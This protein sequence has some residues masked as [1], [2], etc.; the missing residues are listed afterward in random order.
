VIYKQLQTDIRGDGDRRMRFTIST[1]R[2][3]RDGDVLDPRGWVLDAYQKNPIITWAHDYR[4]LPI[5]KCTDIRRTAQGLEA[6]AEFPAPGVYPFADQVYDMLRAGFLSA[7]SV[8]FE[9]IDSQPLGTQ[10]GKRYTKQRLLEFAVV[11]IPSNP[12]A[13]VHR[14][15]EARM[16]VKTLKDWASRHDDHRTPSHKEDADMP[17]STRDNEIVLTIIDDPHAPPPHLVAHAVMGRAK[18]DRYNEL[19]AQEEAER[20][21]KHD[22]WA[23]TKGFKEAR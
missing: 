11:P 23:I 9:P 19:W 5:A 22:A 8:G 7:C 21:R 13:L 3:D 10:P 6:T 15:P 17:K 12:D 20:Q 16:W 14:S 4:A 1:G 2:M 18:I